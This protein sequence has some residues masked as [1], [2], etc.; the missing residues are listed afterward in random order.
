LIIEG[1]IILGLAMQLAYDFMITFYI[2][3]TVYKLQ[4]TC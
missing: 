3:N 2:Q 1:S 4:S